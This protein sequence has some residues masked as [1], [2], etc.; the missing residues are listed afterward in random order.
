MNKTTNELFQMF[1]ASCEECVYLTHEQGIRFEKQASYESKRSDKMRVDR[2]NNHF[3]GVY[4]DCM[5]DV[6]IW[7]LSRMGSAFQLTLSKFELA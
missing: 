5:A 6:G 4:N 3:R 1:N 7:T 2:F